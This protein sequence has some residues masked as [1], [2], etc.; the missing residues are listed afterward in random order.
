MRVR[1]SGSIVLRI[2]ATS[3]GRQSWPRRGRSDIHRGHQTCRRPP[4]LCPTRSVIGISASLIAFAA[5][6][7]PPH[8]RQPGSRNSPA[9]PPSPAK[10]KRKTPIPAR[11]N[12]REILT[13]ARLSF[14]HVKQWAKGPASRRRRR[15]LD[16]ARE[17]LPGTAHEIECGCGRTITVR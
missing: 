15:M 11:A 6:T 16:P 2:W 10:S 12:A 7:K 3:A 5:Q 9:L 14:P 4:K 1:H 13:A 17:L 8:R